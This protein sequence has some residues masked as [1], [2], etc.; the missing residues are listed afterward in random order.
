MTVAETPP[1]RPTP[2]QR[3]TVSESPDSLKGEIHATAESEE[4][5]GGYH[6]VKTVLRRGVMIGAAATVMVGFAAAPASAADLS[7]ALP[8][9]RGYMKFTDD[10]DRFTV[11]DTRAD[12]HGVTGYLRTINNGRIVIHGT[13]DD[14]GDRGCDGGIRDIY[15]NSPHDMLLCWHGG[16]CVVSRVFRENE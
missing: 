9:A 11:C 16:G 14:G 12:G 7:I 13:W 3:S 1:H 4:G 2:V 6:M 10:G 15:H 5:Y 8:N